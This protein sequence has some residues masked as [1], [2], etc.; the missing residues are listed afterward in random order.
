[1][2]IRIEKLRG[3]REK[4][5]EKGIRRLSLTA[6]PSVSPTLWGLS[7]G[8]FNAALLCI[9]INI[10]I[11]LLASWV[12]FTKGAISDMEEEEYDIFFLPATGFLIY[13]KRFSCHWGVH[14]FQDW[15]KI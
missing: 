8:E 5:E 13:T 4:N 10:L 2:R 9:F 7:Q 14:S 11:V 1:M 15:K 6:G 12:I 3:L